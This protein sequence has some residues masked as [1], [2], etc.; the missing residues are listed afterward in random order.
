MRASWEVHLAGLGGLGRPGLLNEFILSDFGVEFD[1]RARFEGH[2]GFD[3]QPLR[4]DFSIICAIALS[5]DFPHDFPSM[6]RCFFDRCQH[7]FSMAPCIVFGAC[8]ATSDLA[9]S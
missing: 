6:L 3:F 7:L 8:T 5:I 9:K 2:S 4:S 1:A